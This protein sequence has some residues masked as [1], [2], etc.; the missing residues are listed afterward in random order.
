[1]GRAPSRK[2]Y[3]VL[4]GR[5]PGVYASWAGCEAQVRGFSRAAFERFSSR[6]AALAYLT[7]GAPRDDVPDGAVRV[8]TDGSLRGKRMAYG[9]CYAGGG[10][11]GPG[12]ER[13]AD[14]FGPAVASAKPSSSLAEMCGAVAALRAL[15]PAEAVVLHVDNEN[16]RAWWEGTQRARAPGIAALLDMMRKAAERHGDVR[17]RPVRGHSGD[18]GNDQA[19]RL[20]ALGHHRHTTGFEREHRLPE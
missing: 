3:A 6:E 15:P 1:M 8:W 11:C 20:A 10:L 9:A 17:V 12:R 19:D 18:P 4:R 7:A 2:F 5:R 16:V 14:R 13:L